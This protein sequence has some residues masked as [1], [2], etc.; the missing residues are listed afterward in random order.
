MSTWD[1]NIE[2]EDIPTRTI[3]NAIKIRLHDINKYHYMDEMD[4]VKSYLCKEFENLGIKLIHPQNIAIGSNGTN[5]AYLTIKCIE[6]KRKIRAL[7]LTPIYFTYI[8]LFNDL[9]DTIEFYQ[10]L[11]NDHICIDYSEIEA[12]IKNKSINLI[13]INNPLFGCGIHFEKSTYKTLIDICVRNH[14]I[15]FIDNI[16]GNMLWH[17]Q[18]KIIDTFIINEILDNKPVIMIDSLT[19]RLFINGIKNSI[20]YANEEI[21]NS[22]EKFSVYSTGCLTYSQISLIKELYSTKNRLTTDKYIKKN[23]NIAK[24][25]YELLKSLTSDCDMSLLNCDCGYFTL[26]KIPYC[27]FQNKVDMLI[28]KEILINCNVLTIPHDRYLYFDN[29]SYCFRINLMLKRNE[30]IDGINRIKKIL[31]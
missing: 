24:N 22:I 16:Y 1:R 31:S 10:V 18:N 12:I 7:L 8:K 14:S 5:S 25:N 4:E 13:V 9:C 2:L 27:F 28:A 20:I 21:I 3:Y 29:N 30:L 11:D 15:L 26:C 17:K 23:I 19:K 6:K